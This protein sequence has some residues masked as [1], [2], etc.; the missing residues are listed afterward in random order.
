MSRSLV[1]TSRFQ[2]WRHVEILKDFDF[3]VDQNLTSI[4]F[5]PPHIQEAGRK[6]SMASSDC[7]DPEAGERVQPGQSWCWLQAGYPTFNSDFRPEYH[8][9]NLSRIFRTCHETLD[10]CSTDSLEALGIQ[11]FLDGQPRSLHWTGLDSRIAGP[12][13]CIYIRPG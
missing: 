10:I 13:I 7:V 5:F 8:P 6:K 12:A 3:F 9:G 4:H 2:N 11:H 1:W